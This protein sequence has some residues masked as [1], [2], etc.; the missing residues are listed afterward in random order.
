MFR[1]EVDRYPFFETDTVIS[2]FSVFFTDIWPVTDIRLATDTNIPKFV[3]PMF[4]DILTKCFGQ[5][6]VDCLQHRLNGQ[7]N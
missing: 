1:L 6:G 5:S 2:I 4:S 3:Y 7:P